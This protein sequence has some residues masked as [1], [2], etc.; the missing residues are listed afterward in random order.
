MEP[1]ALLHTLMCMEYSRV[2]GKIIGYQQKS[3]DAFWPYYV[4]HA[5]GG[6][7]V[8]VDGISLTHGQNPR[9]HI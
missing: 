6:A 8:Y 9:K 5:I 3:A 4:N 7:R 2:C 1:T